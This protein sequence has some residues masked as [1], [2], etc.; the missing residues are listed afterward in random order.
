MCDQCDRGGGVAG[1]CWGSGL[2]L[3]CLFWPIRGQARSYRDSTTFR[4][5]DPLGA[6]LPANGP[7]RWFRLP[8]AHN[9]S[10]PYE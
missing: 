1:R 3:Y 2:N 7:S 8:Q 4:H 5:V 10:R 6:G 9:L